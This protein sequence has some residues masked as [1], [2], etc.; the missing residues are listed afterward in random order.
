M[1]SAIGNMKG[2]VA[3][4]IDAKEFAEPTDEQVRRWLRACI[5]SCQPIR[6]LYRFHEAIVYRDSDGASWRES[7]H[8]KK[9]EMAR[10][11][12]GTRIVGY[13]VDSCEVFLAP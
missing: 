13:R 6:L 7:L 11:D 3:M 4:Q 5:S 12:D 10:R 9:P 1:A 8:D 2:I